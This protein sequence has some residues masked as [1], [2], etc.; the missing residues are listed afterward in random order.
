[1]LPAVCLLAALGAQRVYAWMGRAVPARALQAAAAAALLALCYQPYHAYFDVWARN[2]KTAEAFDSRYTAL[3]RQ[4]AAA[5]PGQTKLVVATL[6]GMQVGG[7]PVQLQP[8]MFLTGSY[9]ELDRRETHIRYIAGQPGDS[10]LCSQAGERE[11]GAAVFCV[12]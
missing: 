10:G 6:A 7:L 9:T 2:P 11:P 8:V 1:M 5:P 3:A 4:I 12:P